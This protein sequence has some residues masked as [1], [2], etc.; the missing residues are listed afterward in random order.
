MKFENNTIY[1]GIKNIKYLRINVIKY[2]Q[3]LHYETLN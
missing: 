2:V 1:N 3:N